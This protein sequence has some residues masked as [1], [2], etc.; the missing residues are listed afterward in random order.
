MKLKITSIAI[1]LLVSLSLSG[2]KNEYRL[3]KND[4]KEKTW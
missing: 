2:Q 4:K 3:E 1:G